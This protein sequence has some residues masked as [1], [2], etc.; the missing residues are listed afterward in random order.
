MT[1]SKSGCMCKYLPFS[2]PGLNKSYR[3]LHFQH[4]W[5]LYAQRFLMYNE[6]QMASDEQS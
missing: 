6:D 4:Q 1:T 2:W 3:R 5:Y